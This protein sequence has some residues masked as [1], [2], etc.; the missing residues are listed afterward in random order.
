MQTFFIAAE[1][2]LRKG[3]WG[4]VVSEVER[5]KTEIQADEKANRARENELSMILSW[6]DALDEASLDTKCS[7]IAM[8]IDKIV[9]YKDYELDIYLKLTAEQYLGRAS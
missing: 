3:D 6:A 8:L 4:Q 2:A 5:I 9:V 1:L 7:I